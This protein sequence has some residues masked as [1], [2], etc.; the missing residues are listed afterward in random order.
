MWSI[1]V[2]S[3]KAK[4]KTPGLQLSF[5]TKHLSLSISQSLYPQKLCNTSYQKHGRKKNCLYW[6]A[7]T[8]LTIYHKL[9]GT[10][11]RN[12]W[13]ASSEKKDKIKVSAG[14]TP[15]LVET[16]PHYLVFSLT[17]SSLYMPLSLYP[18]FSLFRIPV[19]LD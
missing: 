2:G 11:N 5:K 16:S 4:T 10:R 14:L 7:M 13:F 1:S 15:W 18:N 19:T 17:L 3:K 9:G 8:A 6:F 12:V